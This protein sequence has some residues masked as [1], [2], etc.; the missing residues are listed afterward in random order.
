MKINFKL[1]V[2]LQLELINQSQWSCPSIHHLQVLIL[3]S[4]SSRTPPILYNRFPACSKYP[5]CFQVLLTKPANDI[6]A[7]ASLHVV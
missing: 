7:C 1:V 4:V 6:V 5:V 3:R 2:L